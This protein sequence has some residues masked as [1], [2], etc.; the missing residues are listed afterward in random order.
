MAVYKLSASQLKEDKMKRKDIG[1]DLLCF[2][3]SFD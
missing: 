1:I 2:S 3:S